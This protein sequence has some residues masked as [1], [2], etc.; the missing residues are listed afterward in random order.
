MITEEPDENVNINDTDEDNLQ[1]LKRHR[2]KRKPKCFGH[3]YVTDDVP[4]EEEELSCQISES[5]SEVLVV[6]RASSVKECSVSLIGFGCRRCDNFKTTMPNMLEQHISVHHIADKMPATNFDDPDSET[7]VNDSDNKSNVV[8]L[9]SD[10]EPTDS[11]WS[12]PGT[13]SPLLFRRN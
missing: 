6:P 10:L 13:S 3:D 12:S 8:E 5:D 11:D 1:V 2:R 7:N 4:E 9:D